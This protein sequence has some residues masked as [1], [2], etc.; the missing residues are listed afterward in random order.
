MNRRLV[1]LIPL[2]LPALALAPLA[3]AQQRS[4]QLPRDLQDADNRIM[5][6][7]RANARIMENLEYLS[8][9]I[10]PR[11][12]GS[13]QMAR[14]SEWTRQ[15]FAEYGLSARLEPFEI[16][17][18]WTRGEA[19][20]RIL[21]PAPHRLTLAAA[22]W[23][24]GTSGKVRGPVLHVEANTEEEFARYRGRLK[25]AIVLV[26]P[27]TPVDPP[28]PPRL[29]G[30]PTPLPPEGQA[31]RGGRRPGGAGF[32]FRQRLTELLKAEGAACV[33]HDSGLT[34][35]LLNMTSRSAAGPFTPGVLPAAFVTHESYALLWRLLKRGP[36]TA[37]V[38]LT[39]RFSDGPVTVH[40]TVAELPGTAPSGDPA[41]EA[42]ILGAHL[43]S[44]DLGTGTTDNGTGSMVVLEAARALQALGLKP[45][46]TIRFLLFNGE[47]QGLVGSREYV[48]RHQAEMAKVSG[49]LV[50]DYGTGKVNYIGLQGNYECGPVMELLTAPLR[51][52]GFEG[53][54][55]NRLGGTDHLSFAAAGVPAFACGQERAEYDRTH[56]SQSDTF[57]KAWKD[58]LLQGAMVLA[59]WA[60]NLA[61]QPEMLPR[62]PQP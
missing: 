27:P 44:W 41:E 54:R 42:V 5:A 57:D 49:V 31:P 61:S 51:R 33:F 16:A 22:G 23:S 6:E 45:R 26:A 35:G 8:D 40:N 37:E 1:L 7:I 21:E 30:Y 39:N 38:E 47:E 10:G 2:L 48:K 55:T 20:A 60:Y 28:S 11:L 53:I 15:K 50:H 43:D 3:R 13:P 18:A 62:K 46:R 17:R 59:V 4:Q 56:H 34:H 25:N 12:T 52:V 29:E 36:V 19:S 32:G 58:D 24:P 14:A 9:M